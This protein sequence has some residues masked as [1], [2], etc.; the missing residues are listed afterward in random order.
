MKTLTNYFMVA[1]LLAISASLHAASLTVPNSFSSGTPAVAAEV[2]SNFIAVKT[3]V[4]DNNSRIAV[5]ESALTALQSTVSSQESAI[6]SLTTNLSSAN[7]AISDL[8]KLLETKADASHN[9][10]DVY[11]PIGHGHAQIDISGLSS[12]LDMHTSQISAINNSNVMDLDAYLTVSTV[13]G[14]KATLSGINLQ[15]VNGLG[16]TETINGLG[17]LII[18]YDE[19]NSSGFRKCSNGSYVNQTDCENNGWTWSVSHKTGSHYLVA[20][21]RNSYSRY[22]GIVSGLENFALGI[23]SS[24]TTGSKNTASGAYSSVSGGYEN[25]A[26]AGYS[27]VTGGYGNI[28]SAKFSSINGG[29]VNIASGNTSTVTGGRQNTASGNGSSISGGFT[30]TVSESYNWAAGTLFEEN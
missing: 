18:G 25:T 5:L 8:Q 16:S 30:R 19:I 4:D 11:A 7:N 6:S 26:S 2:N 12:S 23:Y 9:H 15:I 10:T 20:G 17:N 13:G 3:A 24:V 14:A 21:S 27:S 28:A 29:L 1:G 22:G